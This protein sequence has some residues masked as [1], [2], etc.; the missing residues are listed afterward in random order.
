MEFLEVGYILLENHPIILIV[1]DQ[2][3]NLHAM[4]RILDGL[5]IEI[6]TANSG[7]NALKILLHKTVFLILLDVQ[8]PDMD[9]FETAEIIINNPATCNVPIIFLTAISKN[10]DFVL[11]GYQTGAVDYIS[12]PINSEIVLSKVKIFK[13]LWISREKLEESNKLL[14]EKEKELKRSNED[15]EEFARVTS[16]D[17]KAPVRHMMTLA[18]F[19]LEDYSDVL[20][21]E[22]KINLSDMIKAGERMR[23]LIDS[24]LAYSQVDGLLQHF[25]EIDLNMIRDEAIENLSSHIN[26]SGAIISSETLPCMS[27]NRDFMKQVFQN[28]LSN[29]IKYRDNERPIEI[30]ISYLKETDAQIILFKD[31]GIGFNQK[32][33]DK[34]FAPFKRLVAKEDFEGTGI[35]LATVK[36]IVERHG[37][38]ISVKSEIGIGS[39]FKL[40]FPIGENDFQ[41]DEFIPEVDTSNIAKNHSILIIDDD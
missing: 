22:G 25:S 38:S 3:K 7:K 32:F 41:A 14:A 35:G 29:A 26:E 30:E 1:D 24:L 18:E 20:D 27:G 19:L 10:E 5:D 15:L 8:M 2:E 4:R 33:A 39:E 17:L 36:K 9:G 13:D 21:E 40:C 16:H 12:K 34:V 11:K 28:I 37:G 6:I 31:T 23:Q